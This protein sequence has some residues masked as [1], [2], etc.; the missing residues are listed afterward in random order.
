[1]TDEEATLLIA[2]RDRFRNDALG[3]RA[4]LVN[5]QNR[6]QKEL[7]E[8]KGA[9]LRAYAAELCPVLD[10][11]ELVKKDILRDEYNLPTMRQ[12]I[13]VFAESIWNVLRVR[14]LERMIVLGV[15]YDPALHEAVA[16]RANPLGTTKQVVEEV[17]PGYLWNGAVLRP[18]QVIISVPAA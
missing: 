16:T 3:A 6:M 7:A 8:L 15:A 4:D 13:L 14:G 12:A 9:V 2:E 10:S 17:R 1:M 18:A 5:Y 11:L